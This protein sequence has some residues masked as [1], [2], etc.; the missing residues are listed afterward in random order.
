VDDD[1]TQRIALGSTEYVGALI[2]GP[3]GVNLTD[4]TVQVVAVDAS[5][6][7]PTA[8]AWRAP[9]TIE[10][11]TVDSIRVRLLIGPQG[12]AQLDAGRW[13]LWVRV[14][15]NPEVPWVPSTETFQVL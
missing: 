7:S 15:D 3:A 13:R 6:R 2:T 10:F 1:M 5:D 9:S 11:P 14:V 8:P 12:D 4:D